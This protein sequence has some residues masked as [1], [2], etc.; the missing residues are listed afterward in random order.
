MVQRSRAWRRRKARTVISKVKA[1]KDWLKGHFMNEEP[2]TKPYQAQKMRSRQRLNQDLKEAW[3]PA[4][5]A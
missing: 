2:V 5:A 3:G 4:P 1:T